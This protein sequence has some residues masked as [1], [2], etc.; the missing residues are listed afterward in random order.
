LGSCAEDGGQE[1][2]ILILGEVIDQY[3]LIGGQRPRRIEHIAFAS[4]P[5]LPVGARLVGF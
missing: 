1:E 2:A 5:S 3:I 4:L